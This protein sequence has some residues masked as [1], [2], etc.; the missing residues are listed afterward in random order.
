MINCIYKRR[1]IALVKYLKKLGLDVYVYNELYGKEE[2]EQMKL[3][4]LR[5]DE[6]DVV[7]NQYTLKITSME[8]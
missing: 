1:N 7:F 2:I 5:F 8:Y 3:S 6:T 4:F